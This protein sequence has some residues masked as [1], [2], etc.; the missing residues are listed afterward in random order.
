MEKL[1]QVVVGISTGSQIY[2]EIKGKQL[3]K[4]ISDSAMEAIREHAYF[5]LED[6]AHTYVRVYGSD[7]TPY[8][9][10]RYANN[11]F[12]VMEFGRQLLFLYENVWKKKYAIVNLPIS[13]REYTCSIWQEAKEMKNELSYYH[14][15]EDQATTHYDPEG[16]IQAF[17]QCSFRNPIAYEHRPLGDKERHQ[18]RRKE[19]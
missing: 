10:P 16:R 14:F 18:N 11:R 8:L 6:L 4:R 15:G 7:V 13:I 2:K 3:V 19:K 17:Y 5:F 12:I 1:S 9:L